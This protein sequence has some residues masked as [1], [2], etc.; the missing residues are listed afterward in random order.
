MTSHLTRRW[1]MMSGAAMAASAGLSHGLATLPAM[2]ATPTVRMTTGNRGT[3]QSVSWLGAEAGIFKKHGVD[4]T[5]PALEVGGVRLATGLARGEWDF[6][7]GGFVPL[8]ENVLQGGD[9]VAL[10]KH[11]LPHN[12]TFIVAKREI[13]ALDQLSGRR[14]GVL[15]DAYTG[16]AGVQARISLEKVG[17][18]AT[19]VGLGTYESIYKALAKG[20]IDAGTLPIHL[21]LSGEREYGWTIFEMSG[22]E[23]DVPSV[24]ATTRKYIAANRD[25]VM[26][27][28]KGH[29]ETIHAFKTQPDV[30]IPLLQRFLKVDNRQLAADM[31]KHYAPLFP[32]IPRI[33]GAG[34]RPARSALAKKYPAAQK[35]QESDVVDSSFIDELES[36]GFIRNL[37]A[38]AAGP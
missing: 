21:R 30:F 27:V 9:A 1:L 7:D 11:T 35:L 14:L 31:H 26:R 38:G 3:H 16:Q 33:A 6:Y 8:V 24:L 12:N 36:S 2:A 34:L 15:S 18:T 20:E 10:L 13:A 32:Q 23:E 4:V 28:V 19:F 37:Y 25:V 22:F 17:A 29:V 5:Y